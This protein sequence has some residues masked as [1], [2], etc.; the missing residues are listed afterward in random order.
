MPGSDVLAHGH[1]GPYPVGA[2][3]RGPAT[4]AERLERGLVR[5]STVTRLEIVYSARFG[6]DLRAATH[7]PPLA[8]M[9]VEYQTT[10]IEDRAVEVQLRQA[11]RGQHRGPS[12]ADLIMAA[13]A[14]LAGLTV[15]HLDKDFELI[16]E[17]TA[18]PPQAPRHLAGLTCLD[19]RKTTGGCRRLREPGRRGLV[20]HERDRH[21][22]VAGRAR[23][24][25]L[26]SV[27]PRRTVAGSPALLLELVF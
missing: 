16:A 25:T 4:W 23:Q 3:S 2:V 6:Q 12:V 5:V 9:P 27:A 17:V 18:Q 7:R 21:S 13:T 1:L 11:D 19:S 26:R 10:A 24:P 14:E 15:I 22:D 8:S 20:R